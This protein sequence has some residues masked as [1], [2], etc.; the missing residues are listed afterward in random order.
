MLNPFEVFAPQNVLDTLLRPFMIGGAPADTT[1]MITRHEFR[2]GTVNVISP[3]EVMIM[4]G[5]QG[6]LNPVTAIVK[7]PALWSVSKVRF[8]AGKQTRTEETIP[9]TEGVQVPLHAGLTADGMVTQ[10]VVRELQKTGKSSA[11]IQEELAR[12]REDINNL[13]QVYNLSYDDAK[14]LIEMGYTYSD[15]RNSTPQYV[16]RLLGKEYIPPQWKTYADI[17]AREKGISPDEALS[18]IKQGYNP[19][20]L[21]RLDRKRIFQLLGKPFMPD[22]TEVAKKLGISVARLEKIAAYTGRPLSDLYNLTPDDIRLIEYQMKRDTTTLDMVSKETGIPLEDLQLY[23]SKYNA[24]PYE[25]LRLYTSSPRTLKNRIEHLK[26][27]QQSALQQEA[28]H[29]LITVYGYAGREDDLRNA[30]SKYNLTA[31][32]LL[33]MASKGTLDNILPKRVPTPT[34]LSEFSAMFGISTEDVKTILNYTNCGSK[35]CTPMTISELYTALSKSCNNNMACMSTKLAQYLTNARAN[36]NRFRVKTWDDVKMAFPFLT[37]HDIE[38]LSQKY[39][40]SDIL[41]LHQSDLTKILD[42]LKTNEILSKGDPWQLIQSKFHLSDSDLELLKNAVESRDIDVTTIYNMDQWDIQKLI[43]NLKMQSAQDLKQSLLQSLPGDYANLLSTTSPSFTLQRI[44]S[45][46][47]RVLNE[48]WNK[49]DC[50]TK[51]A[52]VEFDRQK[53]VSPSTSLEQLK[54]MGIDEIVSSITGG[55]WEDI[56]AKLHI[57]ND[58][59]AQCVQ[60]E[61]PIGGEIGWPWTAKTWHKN[62]P[63]YSYVILKTPEAL[64]KLGLTSSD[65]ESLINLKSMEGMYGPF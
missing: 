10:I 57:S 2:G 16:Y 38:L 48:M 63:A 27:E 40:A 50:K 45:D 49:E 58:T 60:V 19:E 8:V 3:N 44:R 56:K 18:L 24:T 11:E 1:P 59:Y 62:N 15:L 65:V 39:S 51:A 12:Q 23:Q 26:Y 61:H 33:E 6:R 20:D 14:K 17:I 7:Y 25:I 64:A 37:D 32:D 41:N 31:V 47:R 43:R 9:V 53:G 30:M 36:M 42:T 21:R 4:A 52:F 55:T 29:K 28:W 35:G 46:A 54:Q 34:S 13:M 22:K 5:P